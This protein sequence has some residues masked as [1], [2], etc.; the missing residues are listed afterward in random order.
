ME[1]RKLTSL[2]KFLETMHGE[3]IDWDMEIPEEARTAFYQAV[4]KIRSEAQE[5]LE[6]A[7]KHKPASPEAAESATQPTQLK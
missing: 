6:K 4:E 7:G 1:E 5:R 3:E 2:Q